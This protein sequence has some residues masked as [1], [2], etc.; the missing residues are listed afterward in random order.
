MLLALLG[1]ERLG[2]FADAVLGPCDADPRGPALL[3]A[4]AAFVEH[5]GYREATAT[6]PGVHRHTVRNRITAAEQVGG[7]RLSAAQDRHELW[8]ALQDRDLG[9]AG[10]DGVSPGGNG[11]DRL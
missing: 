10:T 7:R 4:V 2:G 11:A 5:N 6:A 3:R 9:R 8:L 1:H